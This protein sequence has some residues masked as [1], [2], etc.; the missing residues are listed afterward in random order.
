MSFPAGLGRFG[1]V[2]LLRRLCSTVVILAVAM[3]AVGCSSPTADPVT[4]TLDVPAGGLPETIRQEVPLGA[5]VTLVVTTEV[6]DRIHV[7]GY[8]YEFDTPA[9]VPT[10]Q[11]FT[12]NMAGAYEIESH[13]AGQVY[14]KLVVR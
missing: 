4:V 3:F 14:M 10:E 2:E 11:V 5:E 6:D 7:H 9:G 8:E 1:L 12:A 13:D